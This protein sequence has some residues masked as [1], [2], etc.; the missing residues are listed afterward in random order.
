VQT[1]KLAHLSDL[2]MGRDPGTR[3]RAEALCARLLAD[4][5][6]DVLVTGDV[7]HRGRAAEWAQFLDVFAPLYDRITLVPGNHDRLGD[8]VAALMMD[9]GPEGEGRVDV[10]DRPGLRL[11]RVD[12][13]AP[14][15]RFLVAGHGA[16]C[17]RLIA[18]CVTALEH[19]P[20]DALRVVLLHHHVL[21]APVETFPEVL[22]DLVALPFASELP[23]GTRLLEQLVGRADLVLHGHRHVP[24]AHEL[25]EGDP[26]R[27]LGV[28]NAGS[29]TALGAFRVFR[30][31][32][33]VRAPAFWTHLPEASHAVPVDP[34]PRRIGGRPAPVPRTAR[35]A[36][37]ASA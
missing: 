33:G 14:H 9:G 10:V 13:T 18:R 20:D 16:L 21:P 27:P 24:G 28:Y 11:V 7:T 30:H 8:D 23:L 29:S 31:L 22:A 26:L 2:H 4:E 12:S 19:V 35:G 37:L 3:R 6:D 1:K 15:N 32:A 5:I 34:A 36:R 25:P 17:D